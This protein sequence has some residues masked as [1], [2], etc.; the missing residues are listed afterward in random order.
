MATFL[1]A[2]LHV[3]IVE[4]RVMTRLTRPIRIENSKSFSPPSTARTFA[5]AV[6]STDTDHAAHYQHKL[7]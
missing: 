4:F 1:L 6:V 2:L 3:E 5:L 7:T